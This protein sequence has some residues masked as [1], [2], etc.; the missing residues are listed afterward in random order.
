VRNREDHPLIHSVNCVSADEYC[1]RRIA[2]ASG[3][4]YAG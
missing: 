3:T 4:H 2:A 1:S